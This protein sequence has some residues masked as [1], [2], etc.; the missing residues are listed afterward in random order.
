MTTYRCTEAMRNSVFMTD[1]LTDPEMTNSFAP[2]DTAFSY[3][4]WPH[5][6]SKGLVPH[7]ESNPRRDMYDWMVNV[8]EN[9][10]RYERFGHAMR[11]VTTLT[12][13]H[14][15]RMYSLPWKIC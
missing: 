5:S 1:A 10:V 9:R 4:L 3:A 7:S 15:M 2:N 14:G 6:G 13:P 8:P 11:G 12:V